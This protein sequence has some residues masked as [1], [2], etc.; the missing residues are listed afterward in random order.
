MDQEKPA[1]LT[2]NST[3][4]TARRRI[5]WYWVGVGTYLLVL[6]NV[7]RIA[8]KLPYQIFAL[9]AVVNLAILIA[10]ILLLRRAYKRRRS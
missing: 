3:T 7:V 8:G 9:G 2:S 5:R 6:L 1:H 10:I 4:D